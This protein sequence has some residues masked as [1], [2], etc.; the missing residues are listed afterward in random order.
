M[1]RIP[2]DEID[3]DFDEDA[4]NKK[5]Y[6]NVEIVDMHNVPKGWILVNRIPSLNSFTDDRPLSS[7]DDQE[8]LES[9]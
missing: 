1:I 9:F 3:D 6:P 2:F 5:S 4:F 7:N 8:T